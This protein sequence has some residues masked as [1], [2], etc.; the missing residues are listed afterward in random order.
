LNP[1]LNKLHPYPFEKLRVLFEGLQPPI[2]LSPIRLS[3]GEPRHRTPELITAALADN[4]NGLA[5]YPTTLGSEALREAIAAWLKRRFGLARIDPATQVI[6]VNGSR[7]ALFAFA[8]CV[9]DRSRPNPLVVSPNPFYQIYEGAAYLAG[10]RPLFLNN[11]KETDLAATLHRFRQ[12]P[13]RTCS[14]ATYAR[15]AT[16]PE[17]FSASKSGV[18]C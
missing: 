17:R 7:E 14:C 16:P 13:G 11:L 2:E 3:I 4:L 1:D 9:V 15:P 10:G 12:T 8:Q 5:V 18:A 6:P